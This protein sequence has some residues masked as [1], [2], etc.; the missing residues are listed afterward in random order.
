M[1]PTIQI[2]D[3]I[4]VSK[5][6]NA[7]RFPG[8]PWHLP[9]LARISRGQVVSFRSPR[10]SEDVFVKRVV[11]LAGDTVEI[12]DGFLYVN[13]QMTRERYATECRG[14]R[15][16]RRFRVPEAS[17]Y[18][19]GDNRDNSEDSRTWGPIRADSVVGEPLAVVWSI[20]SRSS[21]WFDD[22]NVFR[23]RIYL[24]AALHL[25][26]ATRWSRTGLLL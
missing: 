12:H 10:Q 6:L 4:L 25:V 26:A 3:H 24:S 8:T 20:R 19:M 13:G 15:E 2:G 16:M 1:Q 7:P 22:H 23:Q 11:A 14:T 18:V 21:D 9:R 5:L 17:L